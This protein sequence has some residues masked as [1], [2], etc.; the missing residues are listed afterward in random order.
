MTL[1]I[2]ETKGTIIQ[3]DD[4]EKK[5]LD[6]LELEWDQLSKR[7]I[8]A[9]TLEGRD[10]AIALEKA[11]SL[12]V[13]DIL[14]EDEELIV[15]LRS[16]AEDALMVAPQD[17]DQ[18]GKVAFEIG[19]RHLPCTIEAGK[20]FLRYDH[21]LLELFDKLEVT[22]ERIEHRFTKPMNYGGHHH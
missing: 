18:M 21:T 19:N 17:I 9:K 20:I 15:A 7:I 22:Y 11:Y 4:L 5:H 16:K 2:S 3:R 13:G 6:W 8:R 14:Y 10:L 12:Q 1:R